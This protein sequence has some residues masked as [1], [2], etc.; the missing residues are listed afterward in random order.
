VGY[1]CDMVAVMYK[2]HIMEYSP[3]DELFDHPVHPYTHLL[4]SAIPDTE[5]NDI[6][7]MNKMADEPE[8]TL[9]PPVGCNFRERC[10]ISEDRCKQSEIDF[11][12]IGEDHLVRCWKTAQDGSYQFFS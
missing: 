8:N 3:S 9:N 10:P 4:L 2:G 5:R 11:E 6:S 1:L 7:E 12:R